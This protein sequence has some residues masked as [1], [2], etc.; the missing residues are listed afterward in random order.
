[1]HS[2]LVRRDLPVPFETAVTRGTSFS[3]IDHETLLGR[4][5]LSVDARQE[6]ERLLVEA[7]DEGVLFRIASPRRR[8]SILRSLVWVST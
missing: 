2:S 1:M 4:K 6:V 5:C 7:P 8:P 3:E